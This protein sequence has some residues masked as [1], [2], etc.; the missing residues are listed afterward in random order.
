MDLI[1]IIKEKRFLA[2]EFLTWLKFKAGDQGKIF[3]THDG[4]HLGVGF[5][6]DMRLEYSAASEPETLACKGGDTPEAMTGLQAG[7]KIDRARIVFQ[8]H[9]GEWEVVVNSERLQLA[10]IKPPK[11]LPV[12]DDDRADMEGY[13]YDRIGIIKQLH[14]YLDDTFRIFLEIRTDAEKW[15]AEV[16]EIRAWIHDEA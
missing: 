16:L 13:I 9:R 4:D 5:L 2:Q 12:P 3:T 14:S 8:D 7:K 6:P 15:H 11:T 1:D 10:T